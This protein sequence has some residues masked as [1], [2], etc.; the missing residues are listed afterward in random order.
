MGD[1]GHNEGEL[2]LSMWIEMRKI[3]EQVSFDPEIRSIV[4]ASSLEKYFTAGLDRK[5]SAYI[6]TMLIPVQ[7]AS[8]TL[9][10]DDLDPARKA[11][12]LNK[13]VLVRNLPD[14]RSLNQL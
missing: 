5:L 3:V 10:G 12:L 4:L 9:G 11:L 2:T 14:S 6:P 13:H 8:Q 1:L 7:E